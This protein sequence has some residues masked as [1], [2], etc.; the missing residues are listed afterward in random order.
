MVVEEKLELRKAWNPENPTAD[1]RTR[2][3]SNPIWWK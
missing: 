2:Y 1:L 3:E